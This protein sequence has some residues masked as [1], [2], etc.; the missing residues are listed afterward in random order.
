M[1]VYLYSIALLAT[2]FYALWRGGAPERVVA[3][4][5]LIAVIVSAASLNA[6]HRVFGSKEVGVLAIDIVLGVA[7]IAIALTA[8]RFWPL[9]LSALLI[10]SVLLQLAIWYA[11]YYYRA[12][13][14]ILHALSAYPTLILIV[15]GTMRHRYRVRRYGRDPAWS[16]RE[17]RR[18]RN[19][20]AASLP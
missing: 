15:A 1:N 6:S 17:R 14:L 7:V 19:A 16:A 3:S 20:P 2:V 5:V 4:L 9:W 8:E 13:Y 10:L 12:I 18:T 11:P